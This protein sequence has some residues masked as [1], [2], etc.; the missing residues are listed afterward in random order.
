MKWFSKWFETRKESCWFIVHLNWTTGWDCLLL[1]YNITKECT[2]I[3]LNCNTGSWSFTVNLNLL[4]LLNMVAEYCIIHTLKFK[5]IKKKINTRMSRYGIRDPVCFIYLF[6]TES[7]D[8]WPA[9]VL[10]TL[11]WE[12]ASLSLWIYHFKKRWKAKKWQIN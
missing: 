2:N 1:F 5:S 8:Q 12:L 7:S 10:Q 3:D 11:C 6:A 4:I 9:Q